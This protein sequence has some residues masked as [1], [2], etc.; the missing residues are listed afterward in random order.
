MESFDVVS[1]FIKVPSNLSVSVTHSHLVDNPTLED[2]RLLTPE[3]MSSL[4]SF[5]LTAKYF[6]F[7]GQFHKQIFRA[8]LESSVSVFAANLVM[9]NVESTSSFHLWLE[10]MMMKRSG[11][12]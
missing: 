12:P 10:I 9:E 2:Q 1:L 5:C 7:R 3:A 8:K 4:L 6:S 11:I